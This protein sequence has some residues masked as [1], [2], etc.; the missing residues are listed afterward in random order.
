MSAVCRWSA[1]V[2]LCVIFGGVIGSIRA[3]E[4]EGPEPLSTLPP[5]VRELHLDDAPVGERTVREKLDAAALSSDLDALRQDV[6]AVRRALERAVERGETPGDVVEL[7]A[8]LEGGDGEGGDEARETAV[9]YREERSKQL[10]KHVL[11][12]KRP[13]DATDD[14]GVLVTA[15]IHRERAKLVY[16]A[17]VFLL[18]RSVNDDQP[19]RVPRHV[20]LHCTDLPWREALKRILA[21]V[22]LEYQI[23]DR[24]SGSKIFIFESDYQASGEETWLRRART[25]LR[26]AA[27]S[28]QDDIAAQASY[29]LARYSQRRRRYWDAISAYQDLIL[30]YD[31][32]S[33]PGVE[34]WRLRARLA[35][36]DAFTALE[37]YNEAFNRY[38]N[39]I[40]RAKDDDPL[41]PRAYLQA[42]QAAQE[43][44]LVNDRDESFMLQ[45]SELLHL[46]I[47]KFK[48]SSDP[49]VE[50][51]VS[52]ARIRLAELLF[53]QEA[54]A[55][56]KRLLHAYQSGR[57][58]D[59]LNHL[60]IYRLAECD[61]QLSARARREGRFAQAEDLLDAAEQR[62]ENLRRALEQDNE[63][64]LIDADVY[65]RAMYR[66]GQIALQRRRPDHVAALFHF[67]RAKQR[68]GDTGLEGEL[69][70]NL[71]RC[72]AAIG[73]REQMKKTLFTMIEQESLDDRD[74]DIQVRE[75]YG[76]LLGSIDEYPGP[77]KYKVI[78]YIAQSNAGQARSM[79]GPQLTR[80]RNALYAD[81]VY[82]YQR[83]IDN[84][85]SPS[86]V[87]AARLGLAR[88]ALAMGEEERGIITLKEVLRMEPELVHPRDRAYA[89]S[90][91]G[92]HYRQ[93]GQLE[94]AIQAYDGQVPE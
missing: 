46:M 89:A 51:A 12:V 67:L 24:R 28:A 23:A 15:R 71:A 16:G 63:D 45:A 68:F 1:C 72:Y 75:L 13:V 20:S 19:E 94:R 9:R 73:A 84:R 30:R 54:Y 61:Y 85:P 39:Y 93:R 90:L 5:S 6:R 50:Y 17:L 38:R 49:T 2:Y 80:Q 87:M 57:D 4:A 79:Q 88:A 10:G 59:T 36:A 69:V 21:Q 62:Y 83:V 74:P 7:R 60:L 31:G 78:F 77:I 11:I 27:S 91:L 35:M 37:L 64:P 8:Q 22:D 44:Y 56:S 81:A 70:V 66:L 65:R 41:L 26:R 92:D 76:D 40:A 48:A 43:L 32:S 55:E 18:D 58:A 14:D 42:A 25:N 82:R 3:G 34:P 52:R 53:D 33:V 29:L 47:G 86:L